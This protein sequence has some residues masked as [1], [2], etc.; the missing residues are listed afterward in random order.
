MV[1]GKTNNFSNESTFFKRIIQSDKTKTEV[2][3]P[4][5]TA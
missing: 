4:D 3:Y 2:T 5:Y 1:K